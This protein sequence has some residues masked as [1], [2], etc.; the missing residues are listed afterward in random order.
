MYN[1]K[2]RKGPG[3]CQA[4]GILVGQTVRRAEMFIHDTAVLGQKPKLL[5]FSIGQ[6]IPIPS[7][8]W[9]FFM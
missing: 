2:I 5:N 8:F 3:F 7:A 6:Q 4:A 1:D 9:T